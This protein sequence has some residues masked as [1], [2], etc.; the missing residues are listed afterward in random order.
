M[1]ARLVMQC[2]AAKDRDSAGFIFALDKRERDGWVEAIL[3]LRRADELSEAGAAVADMPGPAG[4]PWGAYRETLDHYHRHPGVE[5]CA[6]YEQRARYLSGGL[7]QLLP[8]YDPAAE[9]FVARLALLERY[10]NDVRDIAEDRARG[11]CPFPGEVLRR[12]G[13]ED[14]CAEGLGRTGGYRRMMSFWLDEYRLELHSRLVPAP[15]ELHP[16]WRRMLRWTLERYERTLR[17]F[18]HCGCDYEQFASVYEDRLSRGWQSVA[19]GRD[20]PGK[21]P[22]CVLSRRERRSRFTS[23]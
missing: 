7:F 22:A 2:L 21:V 13:V 4:S 19:L 16:T 9:L 11:V 23:R 6:E 14:W 12:F 18:I 17:T 3:Q 10:Y 5:T 8:H 1:D 20:L 15:A